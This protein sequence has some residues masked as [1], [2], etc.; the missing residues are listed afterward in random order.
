LKTAPLAPNE[1]SRIAVLR[2]LNVLDTEP[3][4]R[5][6]RLTRMARRLFSVPIAQVTLIDTDRQWFKSSAGAPN[7]E[8]SRDI[9]FCAHAIL[10]D[11]VMCVPD[12]G[13]DERFSDN[14]LVTG[15]PGIRFYAGCPL[16]VDNQNLGTLCVIDDKPREFTEEELELLKDLAQMVE[17]ELSAVHIATTDHLTGVSNRRGFELLARHSLRMCQRTSRA[18]T[19]LSFDL[20]KFKQINDS[21]GHAAG[22]VA[23]SLFA[24]GLTSVFRE[25]DVIGRLGGDEFVVLLNGTG[26]EQSQDALRR[27]ERW[28]AAETQARHLPYEVAFS[29]GEIDF[30]PQSP[31]SI[32]EMLNRADTFMYEA[33]KASVR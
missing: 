31:T 30:D 5:F 1:S 7:G 15:Q 27:L 10:D 24:Q 33:K 19:L 20:N 9:S 13:R 25:S 23:L 6:D 11:E 12:A 18:A 32:E 2:L 14:P 21:Y 17:Q 22:D 8:T 28:I 29:A 26:R 16:K 4:E 3:E